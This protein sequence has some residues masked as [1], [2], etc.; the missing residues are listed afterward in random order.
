[1]LPPKITTND[2]DGTGGKVGLV[3][4]SG[5]LIYNTTSNRLEVYNGTG[6]CGIVT[7]T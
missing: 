1:M 7:T 2:R 3:T 6:W 5:A 4:V